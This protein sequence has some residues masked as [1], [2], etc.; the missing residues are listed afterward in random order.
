MRRL[1]S[2]EQDDLNAANLGWTA[3]PYTE[4]VIGS[5]LPGREDRKGLGVGC[6]VAWADDAVFVG[7]DDRLDAVAYPEFHQ[8]ASIGAA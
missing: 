7:V 3:D 6:C 2:A 5:Y 1:P 8:E 4:R